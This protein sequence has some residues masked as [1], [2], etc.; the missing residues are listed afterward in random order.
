MDKYYVKFRYSRKGSEFPD[1]G[2]SMAFEGLLGFDFSP[3]FS[4]KSLTEPFRNS[5]YVIAKPDNSRYFPTLG[6][7][8]HPFYMPFVVTVV[9]LFVLAAPNGMQNVK[10]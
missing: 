10:S 5:T 4:V 1:R 6:S 3:L 7:L 9:V 8:L 2:N